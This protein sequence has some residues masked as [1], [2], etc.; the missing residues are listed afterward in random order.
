MSKRVVVIGGTGTFGARLVERLAATTDLTVVIA[1]RHARVAEDF[2]ATLRARHPGRVVEARALDA[3]LITADDLRRLEAW[4]VVDAAGPF[5]GA[6][7]R[8]AEA[9][10]AARCHY[11]DLADARDFVAAFP[12]LD[13]AARAA[14]VL[15]VTGASSTPGLGQAVL[16][17][18]LA[19]WRRVDSVEIAISPGNR[20]PRGLS[21]VQA[22]LAR[23]GQPIRVFRN[24]RWTAARGMS[25]LSRRRMP[26]LG[27]R[28]LFLIDTPDLDL[29]PQ[30][31]KPRCE[32]IWRAGLELSVLHLGVWALGLLVAARVL[33]SLVPLA[34]PLRVVADWFRG[35]GSGRGG[36]TVTADGLDRD[37][38][39]VTATWALVAHEADGPYV[40]VLPALALVR[41]LA[42]ASLARVGAVPCAGVIP[43][44][45]IAREFAP[46]RIVTRTMVRAR[47]LFARVLG[48][49][50]ARLPEAV[51][52][53]H[54]VDERLV[55]A[56]RASV[57]GAA[58]RRGR[59][60]A[61][62]F[63]LPTTAAD[64]PVSVEMRAD[65]DGEIW[66]RTFGARAFHSRLAPGARR[67]RASERFGPFTFDLV[68]T[69]CAD[70]LD[71]KVIGG[72]IGPLPLP[73]ALVPI[74]H[75]TERVDAQ[76]RF[77]FDIPV[78]LPAVGRL[79]HYRGW[80]VP[81]T[82]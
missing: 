39:P 64:V 34:R 43:L 76:G 31:F 48:E 10:I 47:P 11:V 15:A 50:F 62:L 68:L 56:G 61:R 17:A 78:V 77:C 73:R 27:R 26:G 45:A 82:S 69:A 6:P 74:S 18:L 7:P 37:G 40:P 23:A 29:I 75:A 52:A 8:I 32:A 60:L 41:A 71:L 13:E 30:R 51:R 63:R 59:L 67:G 28:W 42:D 57:T 79:V 24:G 65:G 80:L 5:Q 21:V 81:Q 36:M 12:R 38:C 19:G 46:F 2:A 55:L 16:D 3:S 33:P 72:R 58:T 44:A 20:Q 14:G 54:L 25:L 1:A 4:C 70:G 53:A 9:A 49:G 66:T 35:F 22:I